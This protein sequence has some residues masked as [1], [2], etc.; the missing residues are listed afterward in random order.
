[1]NAENMLVARSDATNVEHNMDFCASCIRFLLV[2]F[3]SSLWQ[4]HRG[5]LRNRSRRQVR[6]F[7]ELCTSR[8]CVPMQMTFYVTVAVALS[9]SINMISQVFFSIRT[10]EQILRTHSYSKNKT[11]QTGES[12]LSAFS[13]RFI[14]DIVKSL[15]SDIQTRKK[16]MHTSF[17]AFW[18]DGSILFSIDVYGPT[19]FVLCFSDDLFGS[20]NNFVFFFK[21]FSFSGLLWH[22]IDICIVAFETPVT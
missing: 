2:F 20:S 22:Q 13:D 10:P 6:C 15:G 5:M 12:V 4:A 18:P 8:L 16:L 14:W 3:L 9:D 17:D 11:N 19:L 21:W 1:M 7:Y